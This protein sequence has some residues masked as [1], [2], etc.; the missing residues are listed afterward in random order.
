MQKIIFISFFGAFFVYGCNPA[1]TVTAAETAP[2]KTAFVATPAQLEQGKAIYIT[3]CGV[4]R[5]YTS[6]HG[7][8]ALNEFT[9]NQWAKNVASMAPSANLTAAEEKLV[10]I[11]VQNGAKK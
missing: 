4:V 11:Y 3:K 8:H 2:K 5:A 6:C 9:P 7:L 10:L 1:K